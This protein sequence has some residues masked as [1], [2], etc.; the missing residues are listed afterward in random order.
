MKTLYDLLGVRSD[1]DAEAIKTAFRKAV[2]AHH[3]DLH[4]GETHALSRFKQIVDA[5][6][7][8]SDAVQRTAYDQLLKFESRRHRSPWQLLLIGG[9]VDVIVFAAILIGAHWIYPPVPYATVATPVPDRD[10]PPTGPPASEA[11]GQAGKKSQDERRDDHAVVAET[12]GLLE[13]ATVAAT[14]GAPINAHA[15]LAS[16]VESSRTAAGT[17]DDSTQL[18]AATGNTEPAIKLPFAAPRFVPAMEPRAAAT[19]E[20]PASSPPASTSKAFVPQIN[21]Q[22]SSD[23]APARA[24][25]QR[26]TIDAAQLRQADEPARLTISTT[27]TGA[28][29]AVVI[30]GL[31][32]GS[33]LSAGTPTGPNTWRLPAE[34]FN[35]AVV[36]PPRGFVGVMDLTLELRL[37]DNTVGD[38]K[39]LRLEWSG[40]NVLAPAKSQPRWFEAAEIALML[41]NGAAF[42]ANGN[43]GAARMMFLPAAEAG[44]P[45]A[46][47]ALAETYDPLVLGKLG[48]KG[49]ITS[50]VALAHSWYEKAMHLGSAMAPERLKNLTRPLN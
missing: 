14:G 38:R 18:V 44:E 33:A 9:V 48:A 17:Q 36:T 28:D 1:A 50:D 4:P 30:G 46:A 39:V 19:P 15:A 34:N 26:L 16:D 32:P 12:V 47:F 49:G 5:N 25:P 22:N 11:A 10:A 3:P 23:P 6:G 2:K 37:A 7:V 31:A 41:K 21:G 40:R 8:L 20:Q 35:D 45:A 13:F 29:V 42:M 43:I 27:D 24:A